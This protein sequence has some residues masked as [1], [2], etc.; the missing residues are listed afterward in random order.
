MKCQNHG[1]Y[2]ISVDTPFLKPI[3]LKTQYTII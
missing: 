3:V 1:E 2:L